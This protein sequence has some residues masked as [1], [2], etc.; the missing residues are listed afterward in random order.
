M[1]KILLLIGVIVIGM[2]LF[3][4]GFFLG[5]VNAQDF[6]PGSMMG[7]YNGNAQTGYGMMGNGMMN[8]GMMGGF[9]GS[10]NADPLT[11][12]QAESAVSNYLAGLSDD[13]L[14]LGEIMIFDNHAYTQVLT[15][16]SGQGAFELLVDPVTG[17]AFPEPGPNMMWNT[18]YGMMNGDYGDMMNGQE[19]GMMGSGMMNGQYGGMMG[20]GMMN[21]QYGGMMGSGMMNGQFD[22]MM[23]NFGINPDAETSVTEEDAIRLAQEYLD[24]N[25]PGT[26]SDEH[27]DTFPGYYTIHVENDGNVVGMLSVNSYSGQVFFHHWHGEFIEMSEEDHS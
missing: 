25:L 18:E 9:G 7:G 6:Q 1:N 27:A 3:V 24:T 19:G 16:E 20:S 21:G 17:N 4:G 15:A 12:E 10:V 5:Q 11:I 23:G 14:V 22:N 2:V 8:G 13:S 26:T